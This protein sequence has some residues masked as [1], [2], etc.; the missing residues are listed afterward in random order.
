MSQFE[1]HVLPSTHFETRTINNV[2]QCDVVN[3][4]HPILCQ[5]CGLSVRR[6]LEAS[7]A[8]FFEK[9]NAKT[10]LFLAYYHHNTLC[11]ILGLDN[12]N[13]TTAVLKWVFVA[14]NVRNK[15]LGTHL[16]DTAISFAKQAH[17][18]RLILCTATKMEAAHHLYR[19]KGFVFKENVTFWKRPMKI[20]ECDLQS[21][22]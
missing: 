8:Q 3:F 1:N 5:E 15:G 18:K 20:L 2:S 12:R 19:K 14:Q 11:A 6:K 16:I 17:Y 13:A 22:A 21:L 10:H 7:V 4:I 9:F